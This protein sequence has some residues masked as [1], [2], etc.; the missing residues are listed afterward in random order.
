MKEVYLL[1][2]ILFLAFINLNAQTVTI[3]GSCSAGAVDG[4]YILSSDINGRPSYTNND[5]C[6]IQWTGARWEHSNMSGTSV[7]MFNDSNTATP[8][9]SSFFPWTAENCV[10]TG[11]ISGDGT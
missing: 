5:C 4:D 10:P 8:P 9:A 6:I 11:T 2:T 7:G 3:T 1:N